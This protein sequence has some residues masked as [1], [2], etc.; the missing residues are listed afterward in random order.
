[1]KEKLIEYFERQMERISQMED[2]S[3]KRSLFDQSFGAVCF[4]MA[5]TMIDNWDEKAE[6]INLWNNEWR[7]RLEAKVY[8]M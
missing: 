3:S 8:E 6:L 2:V 1:M 5:M 4:A 7:A